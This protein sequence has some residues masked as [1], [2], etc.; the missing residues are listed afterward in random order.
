MT[1]SARSETG[2][3]VGKTSEVFRDFGSLPGAGIPGGAGR[4]AHIGV[5]RGHHRAVARQIVRVRGDPVELALAD[6]T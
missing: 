1:T 6:P 5:E 4:G 3:S 2:P